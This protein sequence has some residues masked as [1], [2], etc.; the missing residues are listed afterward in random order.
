MSSKT[1]SVI[2]LLVIVLA[3]FTRFWNLNW[4]QGYPFHP[5][6]NNM[7][8]SI[9]QLT[10]TD[11]NPR[12]FAYGQFPLYLTYFTSPHQTFTSITLTLRFWSAVFSC[13]SLVFFYF[14]SKKIFVSDFF[15]LIF[16]LLLIFTPGLIQSAHFGTTESILIFVFSV[17]LFLAFKFL[18]HP[19]PKFIF[20]ASL[21]SGLGLATKISALILTL[22]IFIS[23]A[24]LFFKKTNFWFLV[25]Y[26]LF[27][28][29][30]TIV[31][32]LLLS[33]F[34]LINYADFISAIKYEIGVAN[35]SLPV[36]YTRQFINTLPYLF[37][38]RHIF[39]YTNG[40][41][42]FFFGIIGTFIYIYRSFVYQKL[43]PYF[44]IT[45]FSAL[46]YFVYHGQ[47]FVKWTRFV[48]PIFFIFPFMSVYFFSTIRSKIISI[49]LF[50]LS[51]L[52]G[53][54]F[55]KTYFTVDNRILASHWINQNIP[56]QSVILS[57][58]GNVTSLPLDTSSKFNLTDFDFYNLD[59]QNHAN[60]DHLIADSQYIFVPS[61][62]VFKNQTNSLFPESQKYYQSLF[63]GQLGFNLIKTFSLNNSLFLNPETA[64]ETWSVFDNPVIRIYQKNE[65]KN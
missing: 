7:V 24:F 48:A 57:E 17:N 18:D 42:I 35:S 49:F 41:F 59:S 55:M 8:N 22:P 6:E 63:S 15:S 33:P 25:R 3:V 40:I 37:H 30:L 26:F 45:F 31:V 12:F 28:V 65:I 34:N 11:L 38:F 29:S 39:P 52:P 54:Y 13:L 62:R 14:I 23:F 1:K 47:I 50:I 46:I 64:E 60:L 21:V 4:S 9:L 44:F 19:R 5:D 27:F 32:S 56:Q 20:L 53:I 10:T 2:Y 16:V 36:F 61:R 51:I 43:N 58:S